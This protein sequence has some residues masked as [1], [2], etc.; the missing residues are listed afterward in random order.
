MENHIL[1]TIGWLHCYI[2]LIV[3]RQILCRDYIMGITEAIFAFTHHQYLSTHRVSVA[4]VM[5]G[6]KD[7]VTLICQ[8]LNL[9]QYRNLIFNIQV[10][11]WF[12]NN[13]DFRVLQQHSDNHDYLPFAGGKLVDLFIEQFLLSKATQHIEGFLHILAARLGKRSHLIQETRY[14]IVCHK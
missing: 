12:I 1:K 9:I 5:G 8:F 3:F 6:D 14:Q 7:G 4:G 2:Q 13:D 10:C 11:G